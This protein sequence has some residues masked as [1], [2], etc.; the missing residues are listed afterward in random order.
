MHGMTF[1][2]YVGRIRDAGYHIIES[3]DEATNP[4]AWT[5]GPNWHVVIGEG[6]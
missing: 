1:D 4:V 2:Q 6:R 5:T 3:R